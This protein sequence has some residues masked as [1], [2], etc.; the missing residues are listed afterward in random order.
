[1]PQIDATVSGASANSY[2]TIG[3]ADELADTRVG[4]AAA[5]WHAS[6]DEDAKA[7]ALISATRDIDSIPSDDFAFIGEKTDGDQALEHPRDSDDELPQRLIDA[8]VEL[9]FI[10]FFRPA[11]DLVNAS[12]DNRKRVKA[13]D[14]EVEFFEGERQAASTL[15]R[16]PSIVQR[17]LSPLLIRLASSGWGSAVVMR[18]S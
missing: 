8:T 15:E 2:A 3:Y 7:R 10:Y 12:P 1:M 18:T 5:A 11:S 4:P 17:L 14:V 6:N 9:G 16:F 13:D